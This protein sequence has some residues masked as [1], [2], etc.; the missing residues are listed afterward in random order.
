PPTVD[1]A[2]YAALFA[3]PARK[4]R[5]DLVYASEVGKR[6]LDAALAA[7]EAALRAS[8]A[9]K[10]AAAAAQASFA[11]RVLALLGVAAQASD[12]DSAARLAKIVDVAEAVAAKYPDLGKA[13]RGGDDAQDQ[14]ALAQLKALYADP[15]V[16]FFH[17][18]KDTKVYLYEDVGGVKQKLA[19]QTG[20]R[21]PV[22][23]VGDDG[24]YLEIEL[25][26]A[27]TGHPA[28]SRLFIRKG[29]D[30]WDTGAEAQQ[31][32]VGDLDAEIAFMQEA[33]RGGVA[34]ALFTTLL[35]GG[36]EGGEQR[37]YTPRSGETYC[38]YLVQDVFDELAG[39]KTLPRG[40]CSALFA[41][42]DLGS[43][44]AAIAL[45]SGDSLDLYQALWAPYANS[46]QAVF[47]LDAGHIAM[48]VPTSKPGTASVGGATLTFGNVIQAGSSTGFLK[49]TSA[50]RD[51]A[52]VS[53]LRGGA[54]KAHVY[55]GALKAPPQPQTNV[56][57]GPTPTVE[58]DAVTLEVAAYSQQQWYG[59]G[60]KALSEAEVAALKAFLT[61]HGGWKNGSGATDSAG[62][63]LS[64]LLRVPPGERG[65]VAFDEYPLS[66]VPKAARTDARLATL[67]ELQFVPGSASCKRTARAMAGGGTDVNDATK[68]VDD[69]FQILTKD[70]T[71]KASGEWVGAVEMTPARRAVVRRNS[72]RAA[73]YCRS[74]LK[75][76]RPVIIGVDYKTRDIN[77]E[78]TDHW[79][80]V[81]G[82]GK[83]G[84]LL[85]NDPAGG[86]RG[87]LEL[88]PKEGVYVARLK[89]KTYRL[90][91]VELSR[92]MS[93]EEERYWQGEALKA[94]GELAA[95][96]RDETKK[97]AYF[98]ESWEFL[99]GKSAHGLTMPKY[100]AHLPGNQAPKGGWQAPKNGGEPGGK[101]AVDPKQ[102][103]GNDAP[104]P[105]PKGEADLFT[106]DFTLYEQLVGPFATQYLRQEARDGGVR[107]LREAV[108]VVAKEHG[109]RGDTDA[110]AGRYF[111][112]LAQNGHLGA[113][114]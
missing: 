4:A 61:D 35:Q 1:F 37:G 8:S 67:P 98:A 59:A 32:F 89:N 56:V 80:V 87:K 51:S 78:V 42:P 90:T 105:V 82:V 93:P 110:Q 73:S 114:T 16:R 30:H 103:G 72:E 52:V 62:F 95:E 39:Q 41:R 112:W 25:V 76:G 99:G 27:A 10:V 3:D 23:Y 13:P 106:T 55:T 38:N 46:G 83:G 49:L 70:D 91:R 109:W 54:M 77:D 101:G 17:L 5:I 86:V 14:A 26:F 63:G 31:N 7:P 107:A 44:F 69:H 40:R 65:A 102:R 48:L 104:S 45:P 68:R 92:N 64:E 33:G 6:N 58:G 29:D 66:A 108:R 94:N 43:D 100:A 75:Q 21:T 60:G 20:N 79:M 111:A 18:P 11:D 15:S 53:G 96:T 113:R 71:E 22:R 24:D 9:G 84:E 57:P 19:Q 47:L 97:N 2:R 28:G 34:A 85:Y 74:E 12:L 81:Y 88:D 36:E 50:W